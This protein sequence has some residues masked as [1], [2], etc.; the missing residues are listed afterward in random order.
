MTDDRARFGGIASPTEQRYYGKHRGTVVANADPDRRGRLQV[1]VPSVLGP[2][3][4]V[5]AEP[6][7]PFGGLE[8]HGMLWVPEPEAQIWVEFEEGLIDR[9]LWVGTFWPNK[10][11]AP[12][13]FGEEGDDPRDPNARMMQTPSGHRILL[14][15]TPDAPRVQVQ[16]A[17][18]SQL[19]LA[20]EGV[21]TLSVEGGPMVR[22]QPDQ[23]KVQVDDGGGN[24]IT[25]DGSGITLEDASGNR[26]E[27]SGSGITIKAQSITLDAPVVAL[28]GAGGEPVVRGSSWAQLFAA[29]VHPTSGGP[30]GPPVTGG[31]ALQTVS[32]K[33]TTS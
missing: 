23:T 4:A 14:D 6:C 16:H 28:G 7:V 5:W 22:L 32:V 12:N 19:E 20:P 30:S 2:A 25:L 31:M 29:H 18:G 13:A 15:D 1:R 24:V 11:E 8:G 27:M 33:V 3:V 17:G 26:I 21:C 10:G 9:P